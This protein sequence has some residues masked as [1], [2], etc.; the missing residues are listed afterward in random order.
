[1][2]S[3]LAEHRAFPIPIRLRDATDGVNFREM[4]HIRFLAT[5]EGI[6]RSADDAEKVWR[7]LSK[8]DMIVVVA[9]GFARPSPRAPPVL[10]RTVATSSGSRFVAR[11]SSAC[12]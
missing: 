3:L 10:T 1:M 9:D 2:T 4:A 8:D 7:Q 6:L 11:A 12:R 5:A